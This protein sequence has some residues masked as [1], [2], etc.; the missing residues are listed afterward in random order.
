MKRSTTRRAFT[1][2]SGRDPCWIHSTFR[3]PHD[4]HKIRPHGLQWSMEGQSHIRYVVPPAAEQIGKWKWGDHSP[5]SHLSILQAYNRWNFA[6][7]LSNSFRNLED[8][9]SVEK[10]GSHHWKV[11]WKIPSSSIDTGLPDTTV[12][13]GTF[14]E[15]VIRFE[16]IERLLYD[17]AQLATDNNTSGNMQVWIQGKLCDQPLNTQTVDAII[18]QVIPFLACHQAHNHHRFLSYKRSPNRI[19]IERYYRG[20]LR[21][22]TQVWDHIWDNLL[23][24]ED[25]EITSMSSVP[26]MVEEEEKNNVFI[27]TA[28]L[29]DWVRGGYYLTSRLYVHD[30]GDSIEFLRPLVNDD[31]LSSDRRYVLTTRKLDDNGEIRDEDLLERT[32]HRMRLVR[33]ELDRFRYLAS[34]DH[35]YRFQVERTTRTI[36]GGRSSVTDADSNNDDNRPREDAYKSHNDRIAAIRT[37]LGQNNGGKKGPQFFGI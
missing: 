3:N 36:P 12:T 15:E 22:E 37:K 24:L 25:V 6:K 27:G 9:I 26:G 29:K 21:N 31:V 33:Q 5:P 8:I 23:A 11:E 30:K 19:R 4:G 14:V 13:G 10:D 35:P 2:I 1:T 32:R 28:T 17:D 34:I 16:N 18:Q 7:D 20:M